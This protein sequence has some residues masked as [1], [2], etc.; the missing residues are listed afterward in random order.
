[1]NYN[2]MTKAELI[3]LLKQKDEIIAKLENKTI[4][5][6]TLKSINMDFEPDIIS[7]MKVPKTFD[8][9]DFEGET[10][11][12]MSLFDNKSKEQ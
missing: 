7:T 9:S 3:E 6:P 2:S 8:T 1:M 4:T 10:V 11:A 5:K 12:I